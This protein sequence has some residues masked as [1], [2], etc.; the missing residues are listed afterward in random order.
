MFNIR[1][2]RNVPFCQWNRTF[3][4]ASSWEAAGQELTASFVLRVSMPVFKTEPTVGLVWK[5]LKKKLTQKWIESPIKRLQRLYTSGWP[6]SIHHPRVLVSLQEVNHQ[7]FFFPSSSLTSF[8]WG[9]KHVCTADQTC[10]RRG[11]SGF[12]FWVWASARP[13]RDRRGRNRRSPRNKARGGD[14]WWFEKSA[15]SSLS[16]AVSCEVPFVC[17]DGGR[18][19]QLDH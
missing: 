2:K 5:G 17:G 18:C 13:P 15:G 12:I 1:R 6:L 8:G 11:I 7:I 3:Q 10:S 9:C 19:S 16:S 4:G 14:G